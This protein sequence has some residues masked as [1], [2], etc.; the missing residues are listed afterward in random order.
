MCNGLRSQGD[1]LKKWYRPYHAHLLT[2]IIFFDTVT[3]IR[4]EGRRNY[5]YDQQ[6][7]CQSYYQTRHPKKP[8]N[9]IIIYS[10]LFPEMQRTTTTSCHE[11]IPVLRKVTHTPNGGGL[12]NLVPQICSPHEVNWNKYSSPS[13]RGRQNLWWGAVSSYRTPRTWTPML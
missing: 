4:T 11:D 7:K 13:R 9:Y 1:I 6:H 8:A 2:L 5:T 10:I 3:W 12:L